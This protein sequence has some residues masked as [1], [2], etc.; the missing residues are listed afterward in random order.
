MKRR[1]R[2]I[3]TLAVSERELLA[4]TDDLDQM[5]HD[6]G[7]PA[8]NRAVEEWTD[9]I[10]CS[11]RGFLIGAGAVGAGALL[12]AC[13]SG[14]SG[15]GT[16]TTTAGSGGAAA[17]SGALTGDLAVA[18]LAASLENLAVAAYQD[19]LTAAAAG[20]LGM[21]PPAVATFATTAKGQH[22]QH[23]AAWN[24]AITAAGHPAVTATDPVL[25]PIVD[26][27]FAKVTDVGGLATL[28]LTL[29]NTAAQTYQAAVSEVTAD[30]S[31]KVAA[32]IQPVEMQHAAILYFVTGQYP[33]PNAFNP[34]NLAR[35]GSDFSG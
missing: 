18:A 24:A 28:A 35:P 20:K 34:T 8:M 1:T 12:A 30:S 21:V 6:V 15:S 16:T 13:S 25:T 9:R 32:S 26:Q 17:R 22:A 23:A 4:M 33:V 29:E 31:V 2:T 27:M 5:H 3:D 14:S 7:M 19:G 11:R 10:R